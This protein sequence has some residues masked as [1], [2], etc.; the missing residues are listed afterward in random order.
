METNGCDKSGSVVKVILDSDTSTGVVGAEIDDGFAILLCLAL[1][2]L[3]RIRL[4]GI[5]EVAGN[6]NVEQGVVC[7]LKILEMT[8]REDIPVYKGIGKPLVLERKPL[9]KPDCVVE[10]LG[11]NPKV[12]QQREHAVDFIIRTVREFPKQV[13]LIPIGPL[14]N[15]AMAITKDPK[16][17]PM[18]REIVAMGGEF[19]G[20]L[21]PG[22]FNWW[23]CPH[24]TRI[25]LRAGIP[26][27]IVPTDVTEKTALTL[28]QLDSLGQGR[29][30]TWLKRASEPFMTH[31]V[32]E[33]KAAYLHDPLAVA[34]AV[35]K[36]IATQARELYVDTIT[37]GPWAGITVGQ[38]TTLGWTPPLGELST[39]RIKKAQ[40]VMEHDNARYVSLYLD[41]LRVLLKDWH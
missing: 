33:E 41:A 20:V 23:F 32:G 25:V 1:D 18:I 11:G 7:A 3:G 27:T 26:M 38:E 35:D 6:T 21:I 29:M 8:G 31:K 15:I 40:V 30:V 34:I 19:N 9:F 4:L 12:R 36:T 10:P 22:G 2:K 17:I 13:T 5:T 39:D 16:I 37:D 28:R 24:S 14:M